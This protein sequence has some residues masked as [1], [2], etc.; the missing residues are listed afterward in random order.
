[1]KRIIGIISLLILFAL[2]IIAIAFEETNLPEE[3]PIEIAKNEKNQP[4]VT[5]QGYANSKNM[6]VVGGVIGAT[7][8]F[9]NE[10]T[11]KFCSDH[12]GILIVSGAD[13]GRLPQMLKTLDKAL[14]DNNKVIV[15]YSVDE[16]F[17]GV[18]QILDVKLVNSA[19]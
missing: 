4:S 3:R 16:H 1:M 9:C 10:L 2:P 13:T 17:L 8:H 18:R 5:S 15:K 19:I 14:R 11:K 12:E 6:V 7:Y